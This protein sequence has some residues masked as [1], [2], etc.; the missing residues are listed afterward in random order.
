MTIDSSGRLAWFF[1][2][3]ACRPALRF[4]SMP[5]KACLLPAWHAEATL[6][7]PEKALSPKGAR[8]EW[9]V[10]GYGFNSFNLSLALVPIA[11]KRQ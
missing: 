2:I 9:G 4:A 3:T 7:G 6:A 1:L 11:G 10:G 5:G 8:Q